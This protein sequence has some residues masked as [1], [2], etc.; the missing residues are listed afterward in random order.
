MPIKKTLIRIRGRI[1]SSTKYFFRFTDPTVRTFAV[2]CLLFFLNTAVRFMGPVSYHA[3]EEYWMIGLAH[4]AFPTYIQGT[5]G[6][7]FFPIWGRAAQWYPRKTLLLVGTLT[8]SILTGIGGFSTSF[9]MFTACRSFSG[10]GLSCTIPLAAA[11]LNDVVPAKHRGGGF[12]ILGFCLVLGTFKMGLIG[13]RLSGNQGW[14]TVLKSLSFGGLCA[15]VLIYFLIP[16]GNR[17]AKWAAKA[18]KE[19]AVKA[20]REGVCPNCWTLLVPNRLCPCGYVPTV[21]KEVT[22]KVARS[23]VVTPT[24]RESPHATGAAPGSAP[25]AALGPP[26][27]MTV[28]SN[29]AFR[30]PMGFGKFPRAIRLTKSAASTPGARYGPGGARSGTRSPPL[31]RTSLRNLVTLEAATGIHSIPG[32]N[33]NMAAELDAPSATQATLEQAASKL[34]LHVPSLAEDRRKQTGGL[35]EEDTSGPSHAMPLTPPKRSWFKR[36][37]GRKPPPVLPMLDGGVDAAGVPTIN[38]HSSLGTLDT[39]KESNRFSLADMAHM[40]SDPVVVLFTITGTL[41][42]LAFMCVNFLVLFLQWGGLASYGPGVSL[43]LGALGAL[44]GN[45]FGRIFSRQL[46]NIAPNKGR[47]M[48]AQTTLSLAL[49][50]VAYLFLMVPYGDMDTYFRVIPITAFIM[51]QSGVGCDGPLMQECVI[52]DNRHIAF[53]ASNCIQG[54]ISSIS[55]V[56][57]GSMAQYWFGYYGTWRGSENLDLVGEASKLANRAAV[58]NSM[59]IVIMTSLGLQVL[60]YIPLYRLYPPARERVRAIIRKNQAQLALVAGTEMTDLQARRKARREAIAAALASKDPLAGQ[61]DVSK[62]DSNRGDKSDGEDSSRGKVTVVDRATGEVREPPQLLQVT[63]TSNVEEAAPAGSKVSP[64][65]GLTDA[66]LNGNGSG[67]VSEEGDGRGFLA[68]HPHGLSDEPIMEEDEETSVSVKAAVAHVAVVLEEPESSPVVN[69]SHNRN[70]FEEIQ[71]GD[72]V[73]GQQQQQ[74]HETASGPESLVEIETGAPATSEAPGL[75]SLQEESEG[76]PQLVTA[77]SHATIDLR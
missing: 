52:P 61:K 17:L 65:S 47:L 77:Q 20:Q 21:Q 28:K 45:A 51:N 7:I 6:A 70:P 42:N 41:N 50:C 49:P 73:Y 2:L 54:L 75:G 76:E 11:Y 13:S 67:E 31:R 36:V 58:G 46:V 62:G 44:L 5:A 4:L 37:F 71:E 30:G 32:I 55:P 3:L 66:H 14:R 60:V 53:A 18:R 48:F 26:P 72:S 68:D 19:M 57:I 1:A 16:D 9:A 34:D 74:Q 39:I 12:A 29:A 15:S 63:L 43:G 27:G 40:L 22:K 23:A 56:L 38:A 64:T 69:A 24:A 59:A 8:W 25:G 35:L 33:P 10:I